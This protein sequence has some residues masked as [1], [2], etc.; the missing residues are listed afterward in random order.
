MVKLFIYLW[1]S[2]LSPYF[3]PEVIPVFVVADENT[4]VPEPGQYSQF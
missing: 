2:R 3:F 1:M 4:Q